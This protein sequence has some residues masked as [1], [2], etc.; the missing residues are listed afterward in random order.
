[1]SPGDLSLYTTFIVASAASFMYA[2]KKFS[3]APPTKDQINIARKKSY[4][5]FHFMKYFYLYIFLGP[6][7]FISG[8][9]FAHQLNIGKF[10]ILQTASIIF[11]IIGLL[12]FIIFLIWENIIE[13]LR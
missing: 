13:I 12:L 2:Y 5:L 9:I 4:L 11:S 1:M 10:P 6:A 3:I 8:L 7:I